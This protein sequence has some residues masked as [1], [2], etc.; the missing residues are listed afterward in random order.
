MELG[1]LVR[2]QA[3][4]ISASND[5]QCYRINGFQRTSSE[6]EAGRWRPMHLWYKRLTGFFGYTLDQH[7]A[8]AIRLASRESHRGLDADIP[9][10]STACRSCGTEPFEPTGAEICTGCADGGTSD[11]A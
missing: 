1:Q 11:A 7:E 8:D 5:A 6:M 10:V 9:G 2:I 3:A 4:V